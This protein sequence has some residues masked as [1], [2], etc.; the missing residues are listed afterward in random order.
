MLLV[1]VAIE[2]APIAHAAEEFPRSPPSANRRR[3]PCVATRHRPPQPQATM[4]IAAQHPAVD[5]DVVAHVLLDGLLIDAVETDA[6]DHDDL[7]RRSSA[8]LHV[9]AVTVAV[10]EL[11]KKADEQKADSR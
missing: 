3:R 5:H 2:V 7:R 11:V 10:S 8:A 6:L 1:A 9:V 4:A